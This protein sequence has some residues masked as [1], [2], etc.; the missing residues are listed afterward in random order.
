MDQIKLGLVIGILVPTLISCASNQISIAPDITSENQATKFVHSLDFSSDGLPTFSE[1]FRTKPR[2]VGTHYFQ[3]LYE[4]SKPQAAF[5]VGVAGENK[6]DWS[7]PFSTIYNW[8]G[9]GFSVGV[10]FLEDTL[11]SGCN[12]GE[13]ERGI[14]DVFG[15]LLACSAVGVVGAVVTGT[16]GF[17]IGTFASAPV[18]VN[19]LQ[20]SLDP[21]R[22]RLLM[23]MRMSYDISGRLTS[24]TFEL[25]DGRAGQQF[26]TSQCVYD[27]GATRPREC[28]VASTP[29][30]ITRKTG[31][32][33]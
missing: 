3:V 29:E 13:L 21:S 4:N 26:I 31:L 22:E 8:T 32:G 1:P 23:V 19:E 28:I 9:K 27:G 33:L 6:A 14:K 5:L 24:Y 10:R 15:K 2:Q 17:V 30:R 20:H 7:R 16:G 11:N 18:F 12:N 25:P